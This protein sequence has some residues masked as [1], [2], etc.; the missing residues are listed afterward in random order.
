MIKKTRKAVADY[1]EA[2]KQANQVY[3]Q[4]I[5]HIKANYKEGSDLYKQAMKT[6]ENTLNEGVAGIKK[7]CE[8]QVDADFEEVRKAI[9]KAVATAP[10]TEVLAILPM[11]REGKLNET[12]LQ[13]FLGEG[14]RNYMDCKMLYDAMGKPFT[15]V[16]ELME[17]VDTLE[18]GVKEYFRTY[19]GEGMDRISYRNAL[20]LNGSMIDSIDSLTDE[21]VSAYSVQGV[22]KKE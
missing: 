5:Q 9:R 10:S 6:A 4:V 1:A 20:V 11:I 13:M 19:T 8:K 2:Y 17:R 14:H 16:E 3:K 15:T 21:F 22:D 12:E 7:D 18:A